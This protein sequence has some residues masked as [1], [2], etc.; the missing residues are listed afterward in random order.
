M[1]NNENDFDLKKKELWFENLM[2]TK[3]GLIG[4]ILTIIDRIER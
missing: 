4:L 3:T 1:S 2:K